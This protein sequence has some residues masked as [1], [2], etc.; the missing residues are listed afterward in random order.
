MRTVLLAEQ[1]SQSSD[2]RGVRVVD[3]AHPYHF[4]VEQ[5]DGGVLVPAFGVGK[6]FEL[7]DR[8]RGRDS[9]CSSSTAVCACPLSSLIIGVRQGSGEGNKRACD[10]L[11]ADAR[12]ARWQIAQ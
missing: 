8:Q 2:A 12:L 6:S 1:R 10:E 11:V 5:V 4:A 7:L 3:R 9:S